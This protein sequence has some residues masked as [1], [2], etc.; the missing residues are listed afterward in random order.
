MI[1]DQQQISRPAP[2]H[3]IGRSS[4]VWMIAGTVCSMALQAKIS[5]RRNAGAVANPPACSTLQALGKEQAIKSCRA[6][7]RS[8]PVGLGL[9]LRPALIESV[10]TDRSHQENTVRGQPIAQTIAGVGQ[11]PRPVRAFE[12]GQC[13]LEL[14][15]GSDD[16]PHRQCALTLLRRLAV[17]NGRRRLQNVLNA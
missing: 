5:P 3:H 16:Q 6:G 11:R 12:V 1:K 10:R 2:D 9:S 4:R 15:G 14:G 7:S 17:V 13:R 8:A